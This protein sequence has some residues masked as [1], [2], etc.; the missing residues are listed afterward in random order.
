MYKIA[1]RVRNVFTK[2]AL[3]EKITVFAVNLRDGPLLYQGGL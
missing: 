2:V 1:V 3:L